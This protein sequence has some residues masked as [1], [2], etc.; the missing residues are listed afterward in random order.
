[1]TDLSGRRNLDQNS[2]NYADNES[3]DGDEGERALLG[4]G[5]SQK[6]PPIKSM[7]E[8]N[9][10]P[11]V[12]RI[13][14]ET[15]P[16]LLLATVGVTFTGELLERVSDWGAINRVNELYILIPMLNNLKG[17]LEMNLS[18]RLSTSA[19][20]GELDE[21]STRKR[22]LLGSSSL[23][24]VQALFVSAV[25]AILSFLLGLVI[26]PTS[27]SSSMRRSWLLMDRRQASSHKPLFGRD[28][29][30]S[31]LREFS[32]VL[33]TSMASASISGVILG[34]FMCT[35]VLACRR[36]HRDPDN[37]TPPIA[38]CL[39]DLLTLCIIGLVS[40]V[41]V[42]T[43]DSAMPFVLMVPLTLGLVLS[44]VTTMR[45]ELVR[46]LIFMGWTPLLAA[47]VISSGTGMV[48]DRF[49]DRYEG[50]GLLSIVLG[51]LPGSVGSVLVSR[52]S[53]ALYASASNRFPA[54]DKL[55]HNP[56]TSVTIMTLFLVTLPVQGLFLT[57]IQVMG[58]T[59]LPFLFIFLF[60]V[61]FSSLVFFSLIV[62]KFLTEY[63]WRWDLDPDT[64]AMPIQSSIVDLVG[65][66]MLVF[67]YVVAQALGAD[68]K[69]KA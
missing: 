31:R 50:Y 32:V 1:M 23:L 20:I 62:A 36:W 9:T 68:V 29:S 65:Q 64:Y 5:R 13:L 43:M 53:T 69:S 22:L 45:N 28:P 51:G 49:V 4:S 40:S 58:W 59:E 14:V 52:L 15:V 38:S 63:L 48:L 47:M 26:S 66:F 46:H 41:L 12:R 11:F 35:L 8:E 56:R 10:W 3:D 7:E 60:V 25:A 2:T 55:A 17:N 54:N 39:G 16:T 34:S 44:I 19:N 18:S 42:R 6:Y 37:I 24:Q 21:R 67:C 61:M 33:C 27:R 30:R 57:F